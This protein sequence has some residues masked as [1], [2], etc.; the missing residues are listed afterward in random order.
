MAQFAVPLAILG[1]GL[2]GQWLL[3]PKGKSTTSAPD[4]MPMLNSALRGKVIPITFGANRV[5]AQVMWTKNFTATRQQSSGKGGAKGGGSG[6]FGSAKG[7]GSA[8]VGYLYYWDMMFNFGMMDVPCL[9]SKGW[10]GPDQIDALTIS[11]I[12]AGVA[13]PFA[14]PD[15]TNK[16][17]HLTFTEAFFAPGYGTTDVNLESWA[18]FQSQM[19]FAC[20]WPNTSYIGFNQLELGQSP[21]VPQIS[22]ELVPI[23]ASITKDPDLLSQEPAEFATTQNQ[24]YCRNDGGDVWNV[25]TN[26]PIGTGQQVRIYDVRNAKSA[27]TI[28]ETT[29]EADI[30]ATFGAGE[31][32]LSARGVVPIAGTPY[33]YFMYVTNRSGRGWLEALLY[34]INDNGLGVTLQGG[35]TGGYVT[36]GF[37]NYS[38]NAPRAIGRCATSMG[39]SPPLITSFRDIGIIYPG[40]ST[41][42]KTYFTVLPDPDYVIFNGG[43]VN[44]GTLGAETR[45]VD[46]GF[47]DNFLNGATSASGTTRDMR[48]TI[49]PHGTTGYGARLFFYVDKARCDFN[50]ASPGSS[51]ASA[52]VIANILP[53]S[54]TGAM[55]MLDNI[56]GIQTIGINNFFTNVIGNSYFPPADFGTNF[57]GTVSATSY[58]DD[59]GPMFASSDGNTFLMGRTYSDDPKQVKIV[60]FGPD[61]SYRTEISDAYTDAAHVNVSHAAYA[62]QIWLSD[63]GELYFKVPYAAV[64]PG[65]SH[66]LFGHYFTFS[67]DVTPP[68]IIKRILTSEVFGF[69]ASQLF[70]FTITED[71]ID[72]A[73]YLAAHT[74]CINQGFVFSVTYD[75]QDNLLTILNELVQLYGGFL[76]ERGG[77]IY[78]NTVTA[79]D[80]PIRTIDNHHLVPKSKGMPPVQVTKAAIEDGYN[81]ILFNYLDRKIDYKQNQVE[82]SDEV[83]IDINGTRV[84]TFPSRYV[85]A[86]SVAQVIATRAL[87]SNLYGRD[88]YSF[89]L[90]WKDA[91][92]RPG[93]LVTLVDSFDPT[94]AAGVRARITHRRESARGK[95]DV[96]A[97][98]EFPY[99]IT[100]STF[101]TTQASV[102]AGYSGLV[103]AAMAPDFQTAYELPK[104]FQGAKA[105]CYFGYNQAAMCM[106]AQLYLSV[107]SGASFLLSQDQQPFILSGR[108]ASS[109][110]MRPPGYVETN[111]DFWVLPTPTFDPATPT[112]VQNY[113]LDDITQAIRAAGGGVLIV[114]S[115][116]VALE[117]LTLLGQNHYRAKRLF[118]GWGGS[119]ISAHTSGDY[120]HAFGAG[121]FTHEITQNDIGTTLQYKIAPYN[122]A[123]IVYDIS[124]IAAKSYTIKGL[125]W[126]PREQPRTKYWVTS[127]QA[128]P[129]SVPVT[130]P[131]VGVFSGD[132]VL[133][134]GSDLHLTWP[135]AAND[136]GYGAG[137]Y[138]AGTFGHFIETDS[139]NYRVDIA[140]KN[141]FAVSSYVV[142]TGYFSY[143]LS[144]NSTDFN[145]FGHDLIT[146]VTP[147]TIKGDG[148]VSDTRSISMNW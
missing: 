61:G 142:T 93:H 49:V 45:S 17:A 124:S 40:L 44:Q 82:A 139:V 29:L 103:Q 36:D 57:A 63:F 135:A 133:P 53:V 91:D 145:G 35:Y 119:P 101:F 15:A 115:E 42:K 62:V 47:G 100:T 128:W 74:Y 102:D 64:T 110:E 118:R 113:A 9:V 11:A 130:G 71:S 38:A 96:Q 25:T 75:N 37:I 84:K 123:G 59:W 7:G 30:H 108:W 56:G 34:R 23:T 67:A 1:V 114:G 79:T 43:M 41:N 134:A 121:L 73:S 60:A 104:E 92:I 46:L 88:E 24:G 20:A 90:G 69:A 107:D 137:G 16:S 85:M 31:T 5:P 147:F 76:T 125:Y 50:I 52:W 18:Y 70:G 58:L 32:F 87:W 122:F 19:G 22:M 68:Y 95:F 4:S 143:T 65:P 26:A 141:G 106:G 2:I 146:R 144:Q 97:T 6:G 127:A 39:N 112:F 54:P 120:F 55:V 21:S 72:A 48:C 3:S 28:N 10:V 66:V 109:L 99:I 94:L 86:G 111:V 138:G 117:N 8:G 131:F 81:K 132:G 13:S 140:S 116:A 14:E 129:R 126:L 27:I 98:R 12:T 83:D 78:F 51:F 77:K 80:T 136:E 105:L 148:P 89:T 33:I